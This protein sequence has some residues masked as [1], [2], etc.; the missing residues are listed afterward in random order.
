MFTLQNKSLATLIII[1]TLMFCTDAMAYDASLSKFKWISPQ[2]LTP[3]TDRIEF[4]YAFE[5]NPS[6]F[7]NC[8]YNT[9]LYLSNDRILSSDDYLLNEDNDY[10]PAYAGIISGVSYKY[11]EGLSP[12]PSTGICTV[13]FTWA[14]ASQSAGVL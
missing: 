13:C 9:Q 3:N 11:N 5:M 8:Y 1:C 6:Y 10:I 14:I 4:M 2:T 7:T 12:L